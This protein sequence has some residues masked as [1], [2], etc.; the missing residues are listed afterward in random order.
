ML[1]E[2]FMVTMRLYLHAVP[3]HKQT[4]QKL[5]F[6]FKIFKNYIKLPS[7]SLKTLAQGV[8]LF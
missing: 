6:V 1:Y 8:S 5:D 4:G 7:T 3:N 2:N